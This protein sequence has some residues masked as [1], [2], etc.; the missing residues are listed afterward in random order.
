M[1]LR[2]TAVILMLAVVASGVYRL[3][4]SGI[5]NDEV[6]VAAAVQPP[7]RHVVERQRAAFDTGGLA[8]AAAV[9]GQYFALAPIPPDIGGPIDLKELV[10][11]SADIVIGWTLQHSM[12]LAATGRTIFSYY[13]VRI[14]RVVKGTLNQGD[15]ISVVVPG[16]R[17][18]F[19]DG[20]MAQLST[21]GFHAPLNSR[22]YLWFLRRAD[23]SHV[24]SHEKIIRAAG[25]FAPTDVKL[26]IYDV[27]SG[28][29][30][31]HPSG[32]F[33]SPLAR[34]IRSKGLSTD[35]LIEE[36]K[37]TVARD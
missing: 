35:G 33:R 12:R 26:G 27:T 2:K 30:D 9:T 31:A 10:D 28:D 37:N 29:I 17:V 32:Y 24:A 20:S 13:D 4:S 18:T 6:H 25:A 5:A 22:R 23:A 3:A 8:A 1:L 21:P 34:Q 36:V 7:Q 11:N 14:E 19:A 15:E 16:G